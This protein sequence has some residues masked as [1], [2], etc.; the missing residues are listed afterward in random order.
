[1]AGVGDGREE[2]GAKMGKM[3][4]RINTDLIRTM[5]TASV[6]RYHDRSP[7][8]NEPQRR[9]AAAKIANS[10]HGGDRPRKPPIG[11]LLGGSAPA[12]HKNKLRRFST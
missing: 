5:Q 7:R 2:L 3:Q 9:M 1:M 4:A 11:D 12:L 8:S 10:Q 6:G